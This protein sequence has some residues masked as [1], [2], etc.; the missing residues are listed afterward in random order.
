[1]GGAAGVGG[2]MSCW[3]RCKAV[4]VLYHCTVGEADRDEVGVGRHE[5]G[6]VR[7]ALHEDDPHA[8]PLDLTPHLHRGGCTCEVGR[9][10]GVREPI[11][12]AVCA[13]LREPERRVRISRR[14]VSERT[15]VGELEARG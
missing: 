7:D 10:G 13:Y 1:M 15:G 6:A 12:S 4:A 8:L 5:R 14:S 2:W 11:C 3:V 9:R